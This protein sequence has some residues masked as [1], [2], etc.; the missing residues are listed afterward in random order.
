MH[1]NS[2]LFGGLHH[3][4][5]QR[6]G[7]DASAITRCFVIFSEQKNKYKYLFC[8]P[9]SSEM[10]A[11]DENANIHVRKNAVE[12][13]K[14]A[15]LRAYRERFTLWLKSN[16][17]LSISSGSAHRNRKPTLFMFMSRIFFYGESSGM[18]SSVVIHANDSNFLIALDHDRCQLNADSERFCERC[19]V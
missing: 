10:V 3:P 2:N 9:H 7:S 13:E 17:Y 6:V 11:N 5:W 15:W 14:C 16:L 18:K 19:R 12:K 4:R 8:I 1:K